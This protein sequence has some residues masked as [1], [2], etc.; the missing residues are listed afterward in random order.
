LVYENY[1][2]KIS[3]Y[4]FEIEDIFMKCL[5]TKHR[6]RKENK[7]VQTLTKNV[8]HTKAVILIGYKIFYMNPLER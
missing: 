7:Q 1:Y 8:H 3:T 4:T 2:S 5:N 6:R